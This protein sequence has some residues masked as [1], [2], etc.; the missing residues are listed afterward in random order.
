LT[1]SPGSQSYGPT[2]ANRQ[3]GLEFQAGGQN[4]GDVLRFFTDG[5]DK[6]ILEVILASYI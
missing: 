6:E 4:L 5:P 1:S 2:S 3:K